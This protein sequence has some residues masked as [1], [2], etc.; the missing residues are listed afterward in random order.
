MSRIRIIF[1]YNE[2]VNG[3][4]TVAS[5]STESIVRNEGAKYVMYVT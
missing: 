3:Y 1:V 2:T 4:V 5:F